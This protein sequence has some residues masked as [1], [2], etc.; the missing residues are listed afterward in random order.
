MYSTKVHVNVFEFADDEDFGA[1]EAEP[2]TAEPELKEPEAHKPEVTVSPVKKDAAVDVTTRD[3]LN[4]SI[5]AM[6]SIHRCVMR[7]DRRKA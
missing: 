4:E 3:L 6:I 7:I 2:E 1:Q 5:E